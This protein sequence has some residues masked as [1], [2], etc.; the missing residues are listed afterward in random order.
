MPPVTGS[1]EPFGATTAGPAAPAAVA[2]PVS[3]MSAMRT[4]TAAR[5]SSTR[6]SPAA[7]MVVTPEPA[8]RISRGP[9]TSRSPK[10]LAFSPPPGI[11]RRYAPAGR[12][13]RSVP[14]ASP[15]AHSPGP[16]IAALTFA[17]VIASRSEHAPSTATASAVVVTEM[18]AARATAGAVSASATTTPAANDREGGIRAIVGGRRPGVK[19]GGTRPV[20]RVGA[21]P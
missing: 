12:T 5:T 16:A 2:P 20:E 7:S 10:A 14:A 13:I 19:R 15:A 6:S 21:L 1:V 18:V 9:T 8:P 11:V 3:V 4:A 17:E